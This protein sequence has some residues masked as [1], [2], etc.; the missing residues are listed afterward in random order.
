MQ[1]SIQPTRA[2]GSGNPDQL[3]LRDLPLGA[4]PKEAEKPLIGTRQKT[5]FASLAQSRRRP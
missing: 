3:E 1:R 5:I 4:A 2:C